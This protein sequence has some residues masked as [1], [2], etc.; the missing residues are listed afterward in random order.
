M[1]DFLKIIV[2]R[3]EKYK[4]N[5][6][7]QCVP[8]FSEGIS[9]DKIEKIVDSFRGAA[10]VKLLDYSSDKDHNRTVVTIAGEPAAVKNAVI[11]A[12]EAASKLI[13]LTK[14]EGQH[15]RMGA[16]DVVP[17]IAIKNMSDEE[18][19]ALAKETGEAIG[20]LGIPVFLYE[21]TATALHRENLAEVRKGQFEGMAD[22]MKDAKWKADY[23]PKDAPHKTAGVTG[24]SWRAPLVAYN[25]NLDTPNLD[26]AVA[27]GKKVRFIGG[28]LRYCKGI[29]LSLEERKITQV[30]MNLTDYTQTSI[31]AATELIKIEAKRYGAK[32]IGTEVIG[33]VPQAALYSVVEY[34]AQ[35]DGVA[36]EEIKNYTLQQLVDKATKYLLIESFSIDQVIEHKILG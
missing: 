11:K 24:V 6:I 10:G 25:V 36:L 18:M 9:L 8:N 12:V 7:V 31:Y 28:G 15:P 5:K 32:V 34:Y 2:L 19:I 20:K 23:G 13:D 16:T 3:R 30:S 21:K 14:H 33:L 26:V 17:F 35:A 22:K 4:M 1:L 29:G 27:I